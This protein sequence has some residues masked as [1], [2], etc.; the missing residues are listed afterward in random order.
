MT[1]PEWPEELRHARS[2]YRRRLPEQLDRLEAALR[3]ARDRGAQLEAAWRLAHRIK[4]TSGSYGFD[5]VSGA[6]GRIEA[7]LERLLDE[8][9]AQADEAAWCEIEQA[10][11]AARGA[12][13][14]P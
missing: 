1:G 2:R 14:A 11:S 9:A 12:C 6:V 5:V 8:P 13:R 10:L 3:R 7:R 4:G